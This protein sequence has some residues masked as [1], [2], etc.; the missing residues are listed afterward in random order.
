MHLVTVVKHELKDK[1]FQKLTIRR[2]RTLCGVRFSSEGLF[3]KVLQ[4][5]GRGLEIN[6]TFPHKFSMFRPQT[7]SIL[8]GI[9]EGPPWP[10]IL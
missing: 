8:L 3:L 6:L 1:L 5:R 4:Q 9:F 7:T 2:G 10:R